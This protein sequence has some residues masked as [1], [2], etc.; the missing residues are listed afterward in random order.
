MKITRFYATEDGESRFEEIE[1]PIDNAQKDAEGNTLL[2][3][4]GYSSPQVRFAEL[5]EGLQQGWHH[6]PTRQVVV[7]WGGRG[8]DQ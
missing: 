8:H 2:F 5:P 4:R 1:I 3:S 6:A 7:V